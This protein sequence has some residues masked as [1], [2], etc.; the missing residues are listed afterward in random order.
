M[1]DD[2]IHLKC[3]EA[4]LAQSRREFAQSAG[5]GDDDELRRLGILQDDFHGD[6]E[7][8]ALQRAMMAS[9]GSG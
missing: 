9:L 5:G 7:D 6:A 1:P 2:V 3:I 4:A 8:E